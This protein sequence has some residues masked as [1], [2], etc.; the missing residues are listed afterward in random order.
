MLAVAAVDMSG[1]ATGDLSLDLVEIG[2]VAADGAEQRVSPADAPGVAFESCAPVRRFLSRKGQRHLSGR[3]WSATAAGHVG[4]ESWLERDHLMLL[5]YDPDVV[6]IA[7]QPFWLFWTTAEGKARSHAPDY[8]ARRTDGS[9]VVIDCRPLDRIKPRDVVAFETTGR[10]CELL[11]WDYR[12]VGAPDAITTANVRWLSG[13]RHPRHDRPVLAAA[14]R[15]VFATPGP[16]LA[17]AQAAGDPIA[18][19]PVLFHLLWRH[20]LAVDVSVPLG[21]SSAVTAIAAVSAA[22]A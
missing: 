16:L 14:L 10:V 13:Y 6:G 21:P 22:A 2:Y 19:L 8:F 11:G 18:V 20:D 15:E 1:K 5:D 17:G 7:S 9:A 4:Y 12:L 3:W